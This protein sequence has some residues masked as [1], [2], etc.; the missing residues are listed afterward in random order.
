VSQVEKIRIRNADGYWMMANILGFGEVKISGKIVQGVIVQLDD[1]FPVPV[2]AVDVHP[3]DFDRVINRVGKQK[4][5][6]DG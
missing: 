2:N 4:N 6:T 5:E 3:D 1:G